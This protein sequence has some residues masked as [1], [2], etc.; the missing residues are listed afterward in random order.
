VPS[1]V[2][3]LPLF[4]VFSP[5]LAS[6]VSPPVSFSLLPLSFFLLSALPVIASLPP[7]VLPLLSVFVL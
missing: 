1:F 7:G 5:L 2:S 3:L 4:V 6:L